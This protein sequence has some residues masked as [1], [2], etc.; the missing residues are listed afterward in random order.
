MDRW[1][2]K[3]GVTASVYRHLFWSDENV[4]EI[5]KGGGCSASVN[6]TKL[7]TSKWLILCYVN[8]TSIKMYIYRLSIPNLKIQNP[9]CSKIQN[10]LSANMTLQVENCIWPHG[11]GCS[12]NCFMHKIIQNV[13]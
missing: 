1:R 11:M 8:F 12:Q 10:F 4:L 3:Q 13:T 7:F 6:A 5:V 9:K 2:G